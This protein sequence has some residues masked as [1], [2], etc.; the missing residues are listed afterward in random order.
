MRFLAP[1]ALVVLLIGVILIVQHN[2]TSHPGPKAATH[3]GGARGKGQYAHQKFYVVQP[4]DI[5]SSISQ[6]TGIP[7]TTLEALNPSLSPNS[8]KIGQKIVLHR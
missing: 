7:I 3:R 4:G 8:V 1:V 6:K 5:L 2:A